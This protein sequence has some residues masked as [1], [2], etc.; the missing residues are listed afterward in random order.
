MFERLSGDYNRGY[1]KAIMDIQERFDSVN[2]DFSLNK[3]RWNANLM[4]DFLNCCLENREKMRERID[5]F[6]RY[7]WTKKEFEWFDAR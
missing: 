1:T 6:I 3:K 2:Y 5:G 7:N 4:R